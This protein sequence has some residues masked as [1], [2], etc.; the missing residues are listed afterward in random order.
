MVECENCKKRAA[1]K[2][3]DGRVYYGCLAHNKFI[4]EEDGI[5]WLVSHGWLSAMH[6]E[7]VYGCALKE[8]KNG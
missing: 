1:W 4:T 2:D 7:A 5:G 3:R 6:G 8:E